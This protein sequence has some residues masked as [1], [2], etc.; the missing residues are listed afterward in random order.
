MIRLIN[1][2]DD[3]FFLASAQYLGP[4]QGAYGNEMSVTLSS[5]I[6]QPQPGEPQAIVRTEGDII[7]EGDFVSDYRLVTDYKTDVDSVGK[8]FKVCIKFCFLLLA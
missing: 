4:Q 6:P 3:C 7:L 2:E 5:T 1:G 8:E